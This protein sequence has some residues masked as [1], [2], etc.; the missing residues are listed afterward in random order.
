MG[1]VVKKSQ[2]FLINDLIYKKGKYEK[3]VSK[4]PQSAV[5][6]A[7]PKGHGSPRGRLQASTIKPKKKL[8]KKKIKESS[9][10]RYMVRLG[11]LKG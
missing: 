10:Y 9:L 11:K 5:C 6:P 4:Y 8:E 2:D 7:P 3:L 1:I